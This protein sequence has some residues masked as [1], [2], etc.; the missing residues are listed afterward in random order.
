MN[1][2]FLVYQ[3]IGEAGLSA[4]K[5]TKGFFLLQGTDLR[6]IAKAEVTDS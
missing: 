5:P 4:K 6:Q 1:T 3:E 2:V